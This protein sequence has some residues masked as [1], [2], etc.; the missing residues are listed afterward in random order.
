MEERQVEV[1]IL[2]CGSAGLNT[3][4]KVR[5]A[6]KN[7]V[8]ID[9]GELGTTCARV[10]CM[11]SKAAIQVAEDFHRREVYPRFGL[12]GGESLS[13]DTEETMEYVRDLR[14][15]FVDRVLSNSSDNFPEGLL[16]DEY[17]KLSSPIY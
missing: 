4:S 12:E 16:I 9:G 13:L 8:V 17:A 15:N 2:G 6:G 14:D 1:A 11:P 5:P 7:V 10:G 3:L